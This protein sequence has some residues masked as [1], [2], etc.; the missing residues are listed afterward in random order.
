MSFRDY[1][2]YMLHRSILLATNRETTMNTQNP[3][4]FS[5]MFQQFDPAAI[6]KQYQ[7]FFGNFSSP[8]LDMS[9]LIEM[10]NKN[11][12]TLTAANR[13]ILEGTQALMQRQAEMVKQV[14]EEASDAAKSLGDVQNPQEAAD[15]QIKLIE[16]SFSEALSNFA[17]INEMVKNTQNET[18]KLVAA[19]FNESL[20]EFRANV[21]KLKP[22]GE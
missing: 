5:K 1:I 16:A 9:G 2:S 13:A 20:E 21:G 6:T 11:V 14:L 17:E 15:K 18:S 8:N 19:R 22:E 12:Q 7:E 3:F 10:Q 4:D